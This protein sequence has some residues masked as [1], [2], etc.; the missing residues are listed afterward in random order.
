[1]YGTFE[2]KMGVASRCACPLLRPVNETIEI[3]CAI[4]ALSPSR[5]SRRFNIMS[6]IEG[7]TDVMRTSCFGSD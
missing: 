6:E 7:R 2:L 4:S 3:R 1:M 5:R